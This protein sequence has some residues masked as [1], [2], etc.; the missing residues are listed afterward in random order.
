MEF[1]KIKVKHPINIVVPEGYEIDEENSTFECIKFKKIKEEKNIVPFRKDISRNIVGYYITITSDIALLS[2]FNNTSNRN[3]FATL[4]Q[5]KS[6]LAM[7]QIS[8][9]MANDERFGGVVNDKEWGCNHINK[10]VI[11]RIK[12]S[13]KTDMCY[14]YYTFLA[15]HTKEQRD[16]FLKENEDLVKDYLMISDDN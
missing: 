10:Y 3:V 2:C 11:N 9:I 1:N 8:Q 7:A 13:V 12:N 6:A 5:T 15:F 14:T 16:L 4:K